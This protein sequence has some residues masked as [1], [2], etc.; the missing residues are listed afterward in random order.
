MEMM[1]RRGDGFEM[2]K[3]ERR[4]GG[5]GMEMME[6]RGSP[7]FRSLTGDSQRKNCKFRFQIRNSKFSFR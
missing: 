6:R 2:E 5:F 7:A 3:R 4:Y 1:E